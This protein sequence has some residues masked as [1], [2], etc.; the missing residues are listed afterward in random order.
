MVKSGQIP[1]VYFEAQYPKAI[2]GDRGQHGLGSQERDQGCIYKRA[3][4]TH[5][6]EQGHTKKRC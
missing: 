6:V 4:Q 5:Q 3:N 1:M 2:Q